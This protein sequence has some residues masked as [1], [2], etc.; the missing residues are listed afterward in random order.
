[1]TRVEARFPW[2]GAKLHWRDR[3]IAWGARN[4]VRR[5]LSAPPHW[6][7][8]RRGFAMAG[9]MRQLA[10]ARGVRYRSIALGPRGALEISP[11]APERRLIWVHGGGFVVGAPETHLAMLTHLARAANAL[12]IAPRYRH[13]PEDPFPAAVDDIEAASREAMA[14]RA[15]VGQAA[16]GGDSAGGC[17]ALVAL[18]HLLAR[19]QTPEALLL[20]SPATIV[21]PERPVPEADDLL[22]PESV[23]HDLGKVYAGD[24]DPKNPRL[25]PIHGDY[26]GA[27][28]TLIQCVCG[29]YLEEDSDALAAHLAGFNVPVRLEKVN[30]MPHVW[31]FMAGSSPL[32]DA[33]IA[34][35]AQFLKGAE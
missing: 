34:R 12:I 14:W 23:L 19:G 28:R 25:S 7:S 32:A 27:P 35:S 2:A 1:M 8:H 26:R 18:A 4:V 11:E 33:A 15:D 21:D 16:L 17:L 24:E 31:Q 6:P 9:R 22:F 10:A 30:G 5:A 29:E 20:Y 13:A 3:A